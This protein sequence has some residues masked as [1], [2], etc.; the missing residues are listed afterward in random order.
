[1]NLKKMFKQ[2]K[3]R[4]KA[5]LLLAF[6]VTIIPLIV[7]LREIPLNETLANYWTD[8]VNTDFFSFYKMFLLLMAS[9]F[10]AI[11]FLAYSSKNGLKKT[12]YYLPIGVYSF[13]AIISSLLSSYTDAA[14]LG[15]PDRYEGLLVLL[16][17]MLLVV[18]AINVVRDKKSVKLIL[19]GLLISATVLGIHGVLQFIGWDF[20]QTELGSRLILPSA[21]HDLVGE[22]EFQF[23]ENRT[24]STMFNPNYVGSYGAMLVSLTLGIYLTSAKK[25]FSYLMGALTVL[26][27]AYMIGS[28]SRAGM[29]GF[30]AG[31]AI[32][33][34]F[35]R[36]PLRNNWKKAAIIAV[37]FVIIFTS[38]EAYSIDDILS[39][40]ITPETEEGLV[41]E[42]HDVPDVVDIRGDGN[43]LAIETE[44]VEINMVLEGT[45]LSFFDEDGEDL[46]INFNEEEG[47]ITFLEEA[48][49]DH[50]FILDFEQNLINWIYDDRNAVFHL[51]EDQFYMLGM[52]NNA[53]EVSEVESWGFEGREEMGSSRGYIWS[54]SLP[55]LSDTIVT[56]HGAD[57]YAMYFPQEDVVGKFMHLGSSHRIVDKP[58]NLFLQQAINTGI[59]SLL[60][61]L[62][63]WG[64]YLLEGF[65]LYFKS[66][67][68]S[69]QAKIGVAVMAAVTAYL[70]TGIFNDSVVSVAPVF[71]VL[72]GTGI[73]INL[74]ARKAVN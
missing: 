60:A 71:W 29:V 4:L 50:S 62:V 3:W 49:Q 40:I 24:Y 43:H 68:E 6:V 56:G 2:E 69:W 20:F 37:A 10:L 51:T 47:E 59:I 63:L 38:M 22:L 35:L 32:L 64:G 36:N 28:Q 45:D 55:L 23:G 12:Y 48:Y 39:E 52:N 7:Y 41:E 14:L 46:I 73:G 17:Y 72:L 44:E 5:I 21:Y 42:T 15:F 30:I 61:L 16:A 18:V 31:L 34:L 1:M 19:G 65:K 67:F 9:F 27:F 25:K 33:A 74:L 58:H 8:E 57:T 53:Y 54:R 66:D 11:A 26:L 13:F 70:V